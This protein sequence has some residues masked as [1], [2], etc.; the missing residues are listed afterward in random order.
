MLADLKRVLTKFPAEHF[1][2]CFAYGSGVFRQAGRTDRAMVDLIFVVNNTHDFHRDNLTANPHHYSSIRCLGPS[3][4][5][6]IQTS[7]GSNVYF[8]THVVVD[9]LKFKYG[10]IDAKDF[11]RDLQSWYTLYIAGRL[12][13]PV[14]TLHDKGYGELIA[15]NLESAV[16]AALLQLPEK[17]LEEDLYTAIAGLS[18]R[19]DFRMI[20]GEDKNKVVNI[21]KP[22]IENFRLLYTPVFKTMSNRL[23]VNS[24]IEQ[25]MSSESKLYHLQ[26]LPQNLK[27]KMIGSNENKCADD[28]ALLE[29][30]K[31]DNVDK[32]IRISICKI[33]FFSSL[34]QSLKGILT[35]GL[36]KSVIYSYSKLNKMVKSMLL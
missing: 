32:I 36:M 22:Q 4:V 15:K 31:K 29:L 20:I 7:F 11:C 5:A 28:K 27:N 24:F 8:N 3:A 25:D 33:V 10:V 14:L 17:F 34:T 1:V 30:A 6:N 2:Y 13:K 21:V 35:A 12:H 19:G 23:S 18:Y 16:H 9:D 26:R